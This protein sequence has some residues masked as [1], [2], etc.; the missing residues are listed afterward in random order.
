MLALADDDVELD[1]VAEGADEDLLAQAEADE[2]RQRT[3]R[4]RRIE[5]DAPLPLTVQIF[6]KSQS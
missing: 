4:H 6:S 2:R 3:V 1:A 5:V